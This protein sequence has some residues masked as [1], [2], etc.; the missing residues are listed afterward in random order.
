MT[1]WKIHH[2]WRCIVSIEDGD[3]PVCHVSELRGVHSTTTCRLSQALVF[4]EIKTR[5]QGW[6]GCNWWKYDVGTLGSD[7]G[8][9]RCLTNPASSFLVLQGWYPYPGGFT[10]FTCYPMISNRSSCLERSNFGAE[11]DILSYKRRSIPW[12]GYVVNNHGNRKSPRPGVVGPLP[13]GL[14][15]LYMRVTNHLLTGMILQVV[16]TA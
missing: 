10:P 13:N 8:F 7:A 11:W 4:K 2:E 9:V 16:G 12:L 1:S 15:G 3:F 6:S 5:D 14:N